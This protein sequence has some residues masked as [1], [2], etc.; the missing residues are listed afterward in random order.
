MLYCKALV[1]LERIKME[2]TKKER[3]HFDLEDFEGVLRFN[4]YPRTIQKQ[5]PEVFREKGL[6]R[7]FAEFIEKHM[8]RVPFLIKLQAL[9]KRPW[10]RCFPLNFA[11]FLRTPFLHNTSERLLLI[12]KQ[13]T[14]YLSSSV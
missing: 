14:F 8:Y 9:K 3:N 4:K 12:Q 10:Y 11:K 1:R 5:P 7:Y 6:L 13:S 2:I